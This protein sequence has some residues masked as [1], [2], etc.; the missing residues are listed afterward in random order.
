MAARPKR[1]PSL[2]RGSPQPQQFRPVSA[3][4]LSDPALCLCGRCGWDSRAPFRRREMDLALV[5]VRL[6]RTS[7]PNSRASLMYW[8]NL[9]V[10]AM[11]LVII[12]QKNSTG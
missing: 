7:M 5:H 1:M 10:S 3:L 12:A 8:L 4:K 11:S 9:A 2:E 6:P